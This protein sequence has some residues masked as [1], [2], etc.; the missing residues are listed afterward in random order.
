MISVSKETNCRL[1]PDTVYERVGQLDPG[2]MAEVFGLDPTRNYYYI[3]NPGKAGSYCWVW[4]YYATTVNDFVGVPI[5]T[6]AYTP[7][8]I[9]TATPGL[10]TTATVTGTITTP[11]A[12]CTFVSQSPA[13]NAKFTPGQL[14][15]DL[16]WIVKNTSLSTWEKANV[17][18]K[19]ISGTNLHSV[20]TAS[21]AADVASGANSR[22]LMDLNVPATSGTYTETWSLVQGSTTLCSLTLTILVAP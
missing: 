20:T 19:F 5:Y 6:P 10:T 1:G 7:I 8:P 22:L 18:Y 21:L 16:D 15:V 4:G 14:Y 2:V 12:A 17:S 13:N 9:N 11:V 3:Q